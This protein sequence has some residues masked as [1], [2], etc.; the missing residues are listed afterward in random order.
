MSSSIFEVAF[1][2]LTPDPSVVA[3]TRRQPE[4]L[5]PVGNYLKAQVTPER[6][7]AGQSLLVRWHD[8]ASQIEER[9]G[10]PAAIVVA[11]WGLETNYGAS[12]GNKDVIRSMATL[13]AMDYRPESLSRR[14]VGSARSAAD[15]SS[16]KVFAPRL[17]GRCD[18][19]ASVHA[20]ELRNL[21]R[22]LG[23]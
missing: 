6:I 13:A 4:L 14:T 23:S 17:M 22:R 12:T 7:R 19:A 16:Y 20:V 2:G 9:Y 18:G 11:V 15:R 5:K 10:V 1:A 3:M 21:R 8:A